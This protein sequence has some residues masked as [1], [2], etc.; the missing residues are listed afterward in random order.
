VPLTLFL[1]RTNSSEII[2]EFNS[3]KNQSFFSSLF[4]LPWAEEKPHKAELAA[5]EKPP[6]A[7]HAAEEK[8]PAVDVEEAHAE[9]EDQKLVAGTCRGISILY[10][11][12]IKLEEK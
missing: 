2:Y 8:P 7:Q 4:L 1:P 5:E 11:L 3:A 12:L 10:L 6:K 9:T